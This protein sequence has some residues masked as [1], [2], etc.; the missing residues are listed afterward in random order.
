MKNTKQNIALLVSL[1]SLLLLV[2]FV[3]LTTYLVMLIWNK[4]LMV[5]LVGAEL[6]A[7][8]FWEALAISVFVNL[9]LGGNIV[10]VVLSGVVPKLAM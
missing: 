9:L 4:V 7:L 8:D 1:V 10:A 3:A 6:Q 2:G 5:K